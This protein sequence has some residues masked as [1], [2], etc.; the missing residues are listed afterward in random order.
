MA[1]T[2]VPRQ[3]VFVSAKLNKSKRIIITEHEWLT[4]Q[5]I[6]KHKFSPDAREHILTVTNIYASSWGRSKESTISLATL[7]NEIAAWQK[8]TVKLRNSI[9]VDKKEKTPGK[10]NARSKIPTRDRGVDEK[11]NRIIA[12]YFDSTFSQIEKEYPLAMFARLLDGIISVSKLAKSKIEPTRATHLWFLW[13]ASIFAILEKESIPV[14]NPIRK[15]EILKEPVI[16]LEKLQAKLP[17]Q[18]RTENSLR[19]GAF[20]AFKIARFASID[21][22]ESFLIHWSAGN[23][24]THPVLKHPSI[25]MLGFAQRLDDQVRLATKSKPRES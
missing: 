1:K 9:W 24:A 20:R 19:K 12:Y 22:I 23:I 13:A 5:T 6:L 3:K 14:R 8:Q 10:F 25:S 16:L 18:R 4:F 21:V 7:E 2:Y 17:Q 15:N 11:L